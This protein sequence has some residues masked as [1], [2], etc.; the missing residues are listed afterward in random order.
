[1]LRAASVLTVSD[2]SVILSYPQSHSEHHLVDNI[3]DISQHQSNLILLLLTQHQDDDMETRLSEEQES[4][5]INTG[6]V[7]ILVQEK[8]I[9]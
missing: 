2:T 1:M 5:N 4:G 3:V 8:S 9:L 7:I 6:K